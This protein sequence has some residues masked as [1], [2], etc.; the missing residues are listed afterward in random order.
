MSVRHRIGA[1]IFLSAACSPMTRADRALRGI[2]EHDRL[3]WDVV[4]MGDVDGDGVSDFAA[5]CFR[6]CEYLEA[7]ADPCRNLAPFVGMYSGKSM[8]SIWSVNGESRSGFGWSIER[9]EDVDGDGVAEIA[10]HSS[11]VLDVDGSRQSGKLILL[12]GADGRAVV[13]VDIDTMGA[14]GLLCVGVTRAPHSDDP[15]LLVVQ[16]AGSDR[17]SVLVGHY[18]AKTG[19][20]IAR[21][22]FGCKSDEY[23]AVVIDSG[24]VGTQLIAL[25]DGVRLRFIDSSSLE[26]VS[27]LKLDAPIA[28]WIGIREFGDVD[29]D[30]VVDLATADLDTADKHGGFRVVSGRTGVDLTVAQAGANGGRVIAIS[31]ARDVGR[32]GVAKIAVV[33]R[34]GMALYHVDVVSAEPHNE[35]TRIELGRNSPRAADLMTGGERDYWLVVGTPRA[36]SLGSENGAVLFWEL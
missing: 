9:V 33:S 23:A 8:E 15:L 7:E 20:E 24:K 27:E 30:G 31:K 21:T 12:S 14:R 11:F 4:C 36:S 18:S 2:A 5:T 32:S 22:Q 34:R 3:G 25:V 17:K 16:R 19:K 26:L 28:T 1:V 10:V 6:A 35:I 13:S 29:G